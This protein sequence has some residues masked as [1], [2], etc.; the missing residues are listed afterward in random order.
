MAKEKKSKLNNFWPKLWELIRPSRKKIKITL[1]FIAIFE[2]VK[3]SGPYILKLIIDRLSFSGLKEIEP[4]IYLVILMFI[5]DQIGSFWGYLKDK[6]IFKIL[7]DLEYYLPMS[8]GKKLLDLPLSYHEKENTG[9]KIIRIERGIQKITELIGNI[10]FEVAPTFMQMAVT[11]VALFIIDIRFGLSFLFFAPVSVYMTYRANKTLYPIRRKRHID[12]EISVGKIVQAIMNINTVKSFA[13]EKREMK[14]YGDIRKLVRENELKEWSQMLK[15]NFRRNSFI[16]L[17]RITILILGALLAWQGSISVGTVIFVITLS[18]KS[19]MSLFRLSRFYDR[20][21][22]GAEAV[23]R[24]IKLVNEEVDIKNPSNG[25]IPKIAKGEVEFKN[26]TF[27]Y[28]S[29]EEKALDNVSVKIPAGCVTALVGP[30]GGGKTTLARMIYRHYDPEAGEILFDDYNLKK[31]DLFAFRKLLAIVPQE[32][33]IFNLSVR[34][35]ISY[36]NPRVGLKEIKAAARIANA[37]EFIKKLPNKYETLVG[38]R[39]IK[40]SG[41]QRQRIGIARAILAN[42]KI[43][44]FDEATSNLDSYSEKLIQE[45]LEKVRKNR[46]L[47]IIAHRL[48]TIKKAD[49]IIVL[50]NGKIVEEGSHYELAKTSGGLYAKLLQLQNMGDIE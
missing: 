38:E 48:S 6:R 35:N 18:E 1:L 21:A 34:E 37:E 36:A 25:V 42:P 31:Y 8:V 24:L 2:L 26:I 32:V 47:I 4:I 5:V 46:T 29:S 28:S 3:L 11:I 15:F 50:E 12:Y 23:N 44:I 45:A 19:Y 27:K 30:S 9:N 14:E 40:L 10:F 49:K 41:G 39:G 16:D 22:E 43:L 17:G 20:M 7:I 33:E 13:Q